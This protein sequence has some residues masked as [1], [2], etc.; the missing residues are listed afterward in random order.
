MLLAV[1]LTAGLAGFIAVALSAQVAG[2]WPV[3]SVSARSQ[4]MPA[5]AFSGT[6]IAVVWKESDGGVYVGRLTLDGKLLD[7]PGI[8]VGA[9]NYFIEPRPRIVFDG[10]N[11]IVG[12]VEEA[13]PHEVVKVARLAPASG[14]VL[15][16]GGVTLGSVRYCLGEMD[17]SSL[18]L[19]SS[20]TGTLVAWGDCMSNVVVTTLARDLSHPPPISMLSPMSGTPPVSAAWNG[21]EWL[22][23]WVE[24]RF[25]LIEGNLWDMDIRVV[26]FS[27]T[28]DLLD[29]AHSFPYYVLHHWENSGQTEGG[30][31]IASDG[32]E[33]LLVWTEHPIL[34]F[35][36]FPPVEPEQVMALRFPADGLLNAADVKPTRL[37]TG[38]ARGVAWDGSQYNV[39]IYS[40]SAPHALYVT[41]VAAHGPIE[42]MAPL[43]AGPFPFAGDAS[44]LVTGPGRVKVVYTR[45]AQSEYGGVARA[46]VASPHPIRGRALANP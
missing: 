28:L 35:S 43:T 40:Y 29:P 13:A 19:A 26:R 5:A 33:F 2:E 22:V 24:E 30:P 7:F 6:N 8:K 9:S 16:T 45:V 46:F 17:A 39:A 32:R 23:T 12:W 31:F 21:H 3:S 36:F 10:E 14:V 38:Q 1:W 11:Y 42:S 34:F 18:A 15:D 27:P 20:D 37:A 44:L 41:Q 25:D 4:A